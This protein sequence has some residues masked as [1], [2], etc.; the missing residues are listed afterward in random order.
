[1]T[2]L[3]A[4]AGIGGLT[5]ALALHAR[6][7]H[8]TLLEAAPEI[9]PLGVGIN[10]LPHAVRVL[11]DL[12]LQE[13]LLE[14]GI[15]TR[16]LIYFNKFGQQIW[17]EPRGC[18]AGYPWPQISIHRGRLQMLLLDVVRERLGRDA[19]QVDRTLSAF[20]QGCSRVHAT[21]QTGNGS[22]RVL[23]ADLLIAADGIHSAARR[24]LYPGETT[25]VFSGRILWRGTTTAAP[26][27][28]GASMIMAGHQEQKFVA[29]PITAPDSSGKVLINWIAELS[30]DVMP[31]RESWNQP[32]RIED[33]LPSFESWRFDWLDVPET[34]RNANAIYMYPMVDRDPLPACSFGRVTLLGD[35]AHPMY[36]IGSNGA[37]QAI[38]DAATL[39]EA[40]ARHGEGPDAL[41]A[42]EVKRLKATAQVVEANR[43]NGPERCM[44]IVEE[45]APY[46]FTNIHDVISAAELQRIA[47][48]YKRLAGFSLEQL[49]R[50]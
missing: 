26:Y 6:G 38:I 48:D 43:N 40:V 28:S 22:T 3:I 11:A 32:G 20:R 33:F 15:A 47:D 8:P 4:G 12:G 2:I 49:T 50:E 41:A 30:S 1:V 23:E 16:E 36:P 18:Y 24:I 13:L 7:I 5:T 27:L 42:Y 31:G 46:G 29:Y 21:F 25:P 39:A 14:A 44:Q 45:R 37:S 19:V 10:L 17:Q 9:Q 34:I 35:A